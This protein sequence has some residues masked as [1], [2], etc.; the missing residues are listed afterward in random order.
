MVATMRC[1]GALLMLAFPIFGMNDQDDRG[2]IAHFKRMMT[3]E[4]LDLHSRGIDGSKAKSLATALMTNST[5]KTLNL[6]YNNYGPEGA[7]EL[8]AALRKNTTLTRLYLARNGLDE[9][10]S[11][12]VAKALEQNTTLTELDLGCNNI[13]D[14]GA[15]S[16]GEL[17]RQNST[18][19]SLHLYNNRI[20]ALGLARIFHEKNRCLREFL[21]PYAG[22]RNYETK[23]YRYTLYPFNKQQIK[24]NPA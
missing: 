1:L 7:L 18:L 11:I 24:N 9:V 3:G 22:L 6:N 15:Q 16:L 10:G 20:G 2:E 8:T 5:L 21:N 23:K 14:Q 17:M 4:E 12:E 13:R 19:T